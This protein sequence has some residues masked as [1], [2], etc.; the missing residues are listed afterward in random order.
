MGPGIEGSC[1]SGFWPLAH[2]PMTLLDPQHPAVH[3]QQEGRA[4]HTGGSGRAQ[5]AGFLASDQPVMGL[6]QGGHLPGPSV[7]SLDSG[8][9]TCLPPS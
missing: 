3:P 7:P 9:P 4:G 8:L 6:G 5:G 1:P 2:M